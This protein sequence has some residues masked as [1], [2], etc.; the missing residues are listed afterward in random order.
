MFTMFRFVLPWLTG[1]ASLTSGYA[2]AL[3]KGEENPSGL[4]LFDDGDRPIR[5]FE[6]G[7]SLQVGARGLEPN[8]LYEFR[9]EIEGL[10]LSE[11]PI[12]F[13][14]VST[15]R[16]GYVH[17]FLLWYHTGVV[18]CSL[19]NMKVT[20]L[21]QGMY[22][23]FDEAEKA[24]NGRRLSV[25]LY[26][27]PAKLRN[28]PGKNLPSEIKAFSRKA[29]RIHKRRN[30][31]VYPSDAEG[32]LLNSAE[33]GK[34]D[35]YISGRGLQP[36]ELVEI[37]V[38]ANQRDWYVGDVI[39]DVTGV[40]GAAAPIR[41]SA[42]QNGRFSAAVWDQGNQRRGV[43]DIIL[44]RNLASAERLRRVRAGDIVSYASDSAYLLFLRYPVGGPTMDIAGRPL[45]G[46]PYFQFADS[47]AETSDPV[48]GAVDPTYVPGNHPGGSYAAY[49]IVNHKDVAGWDPAMGGSNAVADVSGGVEVMRVKAGCVNST[50]VIIWDGPAPHAL[51]NYDVV[52]NFGATPAETEPDY[53]P[54]FTYDPPTDFL[55]GADQV[56]FVV[57]PDPYDLGTIPIGRTSYSQDDFFSS[58]FAASDVDLRGV[59]RYPATASGDDTPV[60][61]GTHLLFL[62]EHGN[63][64]TCEVARD[65]RDPYDVLDD[66]LGGLITWSQFLALLYN[67]DDCP[68]RKPNHEGYMRLLDILASHGI[69]AVSIDAY[70]LT[71]CTTTGCRPQWITERGTLIIKH[72]ELWSHLNT[73]SQFPTYPGFFSGRFNGHVDTN[74]I[75]VSGHSRGGEASVAAFMLNNT[76]NNKGC[77]QAGLNNKGCISSPLECTLYC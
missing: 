63:H 77:I 29:V 43:Y 42:D 4:T 34:R 62:M 67:Y 69:I 46:T 14:R 50:Y 25:S 11:Q 1:L 3:E 57:A 7:S 71:S 2:L 64:L 76:F 48:W 20:K 70:D 33:V 16:T 49:F 35:M 23:S 53:D 74:K 24:F 73:P 31:M 37:S 38:V 52:V 60:A 40:G 9:L 12:S 72:L 59:V 5:T 58:I 47:F 26:L 41:V 32:C 54:D 27:I 10:D 28:S 39:N 75:S 44:A 68:D 56:G 66:V 18:G 51:G 30:P 65:G 61:A 22:R 21:P 15:D 8:A 36:G 45:F 6:V 17:P 19:Q 13:A 55:D